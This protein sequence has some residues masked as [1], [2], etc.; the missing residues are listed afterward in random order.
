LVIT[1]LLYGYLDH[2]VKAAWLHIPLY[3][4]IQIAMYFVNYRF[5]QGW[6]FREKK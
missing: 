6:V 2:F 4:V 1:T 5:Q 3:V